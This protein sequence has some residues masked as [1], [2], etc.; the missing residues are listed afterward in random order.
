MIQFL[1]HSKSESV[2]NNPPKAVFEQRIKVLENSERK[3]CE[4]EDRQG[5]EGNERTKHLKCEEELA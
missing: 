5:K 3:I 1:P 2:K 4:E